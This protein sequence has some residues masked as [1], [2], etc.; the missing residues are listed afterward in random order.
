MCRSIAWTA[1]WP[2]ACAGCAARLSPM[3]A[4]RSEEHTSELQSLRHLVC[5]LLLEKKKHNS[6]SDNIREQ[7]GDF[8]GFDEVEFGSHV[9]HNVMLHRYALDPATE[10]ET[11]HHETDTTLLHSE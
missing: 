3:T 7:K 8:P 11:P 2:T 1:T 6:Y 10:N 4:W 9:L 5:R